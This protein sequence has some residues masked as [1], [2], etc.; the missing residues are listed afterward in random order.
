MS[1]LTP[2]QPRQGR[3]F[4]LWLLLSLTLLVGVFLVGVLSLTGRVVTTPEWMTAHIE[5]RLNQALYP[6]QLELGGA[7]VVFSR[8]HAPQ[9]HLNNVVV[10]DAKGQSLA[11]LPDLQAVIAARPLL[12]RK[13]VV[14]RVALT[15]AELT[16]RRRVDGQFDLALGDTSA[17]LVGEVG[18]LQVL[19]Q[20]DQALALPALASIEDVTVESLQLTYVD[21]RAGRSWQVDNGLLALEQTPQDVSARV[22]FS[23]V[24]DLGVPSE[25][26]VNFETV[27]GSPEARMSA[28]FS[29]VAAADIAAQSPALAF[30]TVI[31]APISGALRTGVGPEGGLAPLNAALEIGSGALRPVEEAAPIRFDR[32]KAYFSFDPGNDRIDLAEIALDTSAVRL[33]AEGHAY[34]RDKVSGW[35]TSL[36]TQ[37]RLREV[38]LNPGGIF[39]APATF[40][41]G[42][43]D[44]K[45]ALDPFTVTIGQ[46][47]LGDST[48]AT[49]RGKGSVRARE[50]GWKVDLDLNLDRIS[51]GRLLALWP[52]DLA[53]GTRKWVTNNILSGEFFEV[54]AALRLAPDNPPVIS[55]THEFRDAN[56]QFMRTMPPVDNGYG[57]ITI[58][59]QTFTMVLG[60]GTITAPQGGL[61]DVAGTV[62]HIPNTKQKPARGEVTLKTES[63]VEA[64]LSL[65]DQPPLGLMARAGQPVNLADGRAS[66]EAKIAL[67]LAKGNTPEKIEYAAKG[68]LRNVRSDVLVKNRSLA[69]QQ[70]SISADKEQISISGQATLDGVPVNGVWTQVLGPKNKGRSRVEGTVE[71]SQNFVEKFNI[72]LPKGSVTGRGLGAIDLR[73]NKGQPTRFTLNSDMNQLG[74]KLPSL[75]WTK[76]KNTKGT[77]KVAGTLGSPPNIESLSIK[78]AGLTAD[79]KIS[80]AKNGGL[81]EAAFSRVQIGRWLDA[82]VTLKGRGANRA[83]AVVLRGGRFV[84]RDSPFG[85]GRSGGGRSGQGGPIDIALD[86]LVISDGITLADVRGSLSSAGGLN[87]GLRGRV[88]RGAPITATLT[89]SKNG[90]AIRVQSDD[91]GGVLKGAGIFEKSRGGTLDLSLT[92]RGRA[93]EYNGKLKI[94]R[95]RVK[96]APALAEL[97]SAISV[98]GILEMLDGDGLVFNDVSADFR[99]TPTALQVKSGSAVGPSLGISMAGLFDLKAN[100][101]DMQGVI[102]P[103]YILNGI[104]SVLTRKG[105]GLFGF[106][107]RLTGNAKNP[108]VSVNPLSILTPGMFREIFRRPVPEIAN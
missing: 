30:L 40:G 97:L 96:G 103:I 106:N 4:G 35:P 28:N 7:S 98:V 18:L 105:E 56:V 50:D 67:P 65:L 37:M 85:G 10:A 59:D 52:I 87:G 31:D 54:N 84:L 25:V 34:L 42:A 100:R 74:L 66:V 95:T 91:A 36:I 41:E 107:Y 89:P 19:D 23:L 47:M 8:E 15:G 58:T 3:R 51:E 102:S 76:S 70:L 86:R 57:Y 101:M 99:L 77:L 9:V 21:A 38:S 78:A 92:P 16:L 39:E 80:V 6:M 48:G 61:V 64:V 2:P 68:V 43:L 17:P 62:F 104:G 44:L 72:G 33:R 69:A 5:E 27:K 45:L 32:G 60:S 46:V 14:R 12:E 53:P 29:D 13:L 11:R 88:V 94:S 49:Y 73:L 55:L 24:N 63:S 90:T 26:A 108:S 71:L 82:P 20:I 79:G 22:F 83:P 1:N 81:Q 93:G 75:G